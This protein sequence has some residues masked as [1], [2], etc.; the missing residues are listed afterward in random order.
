MLDYRGGSSIN[1]RHL[2][3][4]S[5]L[6]PGGRKTP[7]RPLAIIS[8]TGGQTNCPLCDRRTHTHHLPDWYGSLSTPTSLLNVHCF[9]TTPQSRLVVANGSP[10]STSGSWT[11]TLQLNGFTFTGTFQLLDVRLPIIGADFL[12][13]HKL[14]VDIA[15]RHLLLPSLT[16]SIPCSPSSFPSL[17]ISTVSPACLF[18]SLL[19][20]YPRITTPVFNNASPSHGICH[21]IPTQRP[22]VWAGPCCLYS[23]KLA[24]TPGTRYH[25]PVVQWV[26]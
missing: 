8:S 18:L 21:W 4:V 20:W 13:K 12:R 15:R 26:G 3:S 16:S 11:R 22:P 1:L 6:V 7:T 2:H 9:S 14:L 10:I 19:K 25:P 24:V 5:P 17:Q 23:N